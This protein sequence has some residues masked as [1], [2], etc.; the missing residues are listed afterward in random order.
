MRVL[1]YAQ[2]LESYAALTL[3]SLAG[4]FGVSE[5]FVDACVS[6]SSPPLP[7]IP[8]M[9]R[10]HVALLERAWVAYL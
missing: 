8:Y 2:L 3:R 5:A 9:P 10:L 4:A 1:A 7:A 6:S